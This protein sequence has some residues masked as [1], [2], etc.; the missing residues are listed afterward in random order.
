LDKVSQFY[1]YSD[2]IIKNN[3]APLLLKYKQSTQ[4]M[5]G[6]DRQNHERP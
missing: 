4:L 1:Q 5:K 2:I 6:K 3:F